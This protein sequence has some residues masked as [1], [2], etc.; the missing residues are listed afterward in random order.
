[1]LVALIVLLTLSS[2]HE[3]L[4][5]LAAWCRLKWGEE[6]VTE[7][8][9]DAGCDEEGEGSVVKDEDAACVEAVAGVVLEAAAQWAD[10]F[11]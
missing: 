4:Q 6:V 8:P 11:A 2:E 10:M 7:A 1:M 3:Q 5:L 9:L